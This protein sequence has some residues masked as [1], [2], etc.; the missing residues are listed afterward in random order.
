[1]PALSIPV[2]IILLLVALFFGGIGGRVG[3]YGYGYGHSGMA[4]IGALILI[5]TAL[6]A[7]GSL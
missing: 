5:L 3:G 1:M 6:V 4:V 7:S 2:F